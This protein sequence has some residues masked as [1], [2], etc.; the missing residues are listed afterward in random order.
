MHYLL[1]N[2]LNLRCLFSH[3]QIRL[4]DGTTMRGNFRLLASLHQ[5]NPC[6]IKATNRN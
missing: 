6:K 4:L 3:L 5:T 2:Y 1:H